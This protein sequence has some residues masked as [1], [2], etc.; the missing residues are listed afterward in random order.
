M[1]FL[2][3]HQ[4]KNTTLNQRQMDDQVTLFQDHEQRCIWS[5]YHPDCLSP[6]FALVGIE[7]KCSGNGINSEFAIIGALLLSL[8][9]VPLMSSLLLSKDRSK[10]DLSERFIR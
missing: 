9:C 8:T 7:G 5:I 10:E 6:I 1:M 2:L 3:H 4:F